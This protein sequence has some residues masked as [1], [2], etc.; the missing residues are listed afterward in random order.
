MRKEVA[1]TKNTTATDFDIFVYEIHL[2]ARKVLGLN[3]KLVSLLDIADAPATALMTS[4]AH[5][6]IYRLQTCSM[7]GEKR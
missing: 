1:R 4:W 6:L 5:V 3:F 7:T 2:A